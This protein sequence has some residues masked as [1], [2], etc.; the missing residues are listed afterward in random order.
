MFSVMYITYTYISSGLVSFSVP[1][2]GRYQLIKWCLLA[3]RGTNNERFLSRVCY[4]LHVC[5]SVFISGDAKQP[6]SFCDI[7]QA[8]DSV[9]TDAAHVTLAT[10]ATDER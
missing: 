5:L 7:L 4:G 1:A 3:R 2:R 10:T 6:H 9:A 8:K